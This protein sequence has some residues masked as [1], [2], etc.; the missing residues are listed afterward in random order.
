MPSV[1]VGIIKF[2][3]PIPVFLVL[4]LTVDLKAMQIHGDFLDRR[5]FKC[6]EGLDLYLYKSGVQG[7]IHFTDM[8]S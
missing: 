1:W 2:I 3:V 5:G 4:L 6:S 7:G 8:F